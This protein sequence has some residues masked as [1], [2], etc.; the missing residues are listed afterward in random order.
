MYQ[1]DA[2]KL[3]RYTATSQGTLRRKTEGNHAPSQAR[4][5]AVTAP[6][7]PSDQRTLND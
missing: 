7:V 1:T 6:R 2:D 5:K 4:D 3:K